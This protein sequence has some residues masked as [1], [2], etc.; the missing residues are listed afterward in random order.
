VT[1]PDTYCT[2]SYSPV[3]PSE[4]AP[5]RKNNKIIVKRKEK[6]KS[7]HGPQRGARCQDELIEWLS[8]A[9]RTIQ[10]MVYSLAIC[11]TLLSCSA[12]FSTLKMEIICSSETS[13]NIRTT[14]SY[15]PEDSTICSYSCDIFKSYRRFTDFEIIFFWNVSY[16]IIKSGYE[17]PE[18]NS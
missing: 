17:C 12:W 10:P 2:A 13:V 16:F 11:R 7:D 4:R 15:I 3:L 8:A 14:L 9:R 5:Y 18:G 1:W 6:I